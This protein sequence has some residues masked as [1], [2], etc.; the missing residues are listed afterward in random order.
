MAKYETFKINHVL[1]STD[2]GCDC[3]GDVKLVLPKCGKW[4]KARCD[5]CKTEWR[6]R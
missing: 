1:N 3:G 2:F 6:L 4:W 5:V